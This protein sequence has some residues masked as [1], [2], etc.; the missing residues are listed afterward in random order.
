MPSENNHIDNF[1][2]NKASEA[3]VDASRMDADWQQMKEMLVK[4]SSLPSSRTLRFRRYLPYA[5]GVIMVVTTVT[6]MLSPGKKTK[7]EQLAVAT[8]KTVAPGVDRT[9]K[10]RTTVPFKNTTASSTTSSNIAP[11]RKQAVKHEAKTIKKPTFATVK[12]SA[13]VVTKD[14]LTETIAATTP[15]PK[16][17]FNN[18]YNDLKKPAQEFNVNT[19]G[20]TTILCAEGSSLFVPAGAFQ[21]VAGLAITGTVRISIQE[22][23]SFAD[24][25]SNKLSTTSNSIPLETGGMLSINASS[26]GE[27]VVIK[28]GTSLDLKMP[29]HSFNPQMQLFTGQHRLT[30]MDTVKA[31]LPGA[32]NTEILGET[33][34]VHFDTTAKSARAN[35][36]SLA[37]LAGSID[38][39]PVGQQQYF[40]AENRKVIT[41]FNATDNPYHIGSDWT[42]K[43]IAKFAIPYSASIS[44]TEMKDILETKYGR[45][46]DKIKVKRAWRS[47]V[48]KNRTYKHT[49]T[50][51][52]ER[53]RVI[54]DWY[55]TTFV[56]DSIRI[57][58]QLACRLKM[59]SPEDSL[60]WE[61]KFKQQLETAMKQKWAYQEMLQKRNEYSFKITNLGWINCDRFLEYPS[62]RLTA[63][64]FKA[65]AGFDHKNFQAILVFDKEKSVMQG[66]LQNDEVRFGNIPVGHTVHLICTG[67]RNG[68]MQVSMQTFV[69]EKFQKP[70]LLFEET[71]KDQFRQKLAQL[72]NVK[73]I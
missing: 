64:A 45:Y 4:P 68:K 22:F 66:Y 34:R 55:K 14:S 2:R 53:D 42:G 18:F 13:G 23:Y 41:L 12:Q 39:S 10:P 17:I 67:V 57:P 8:K 43:S 56:G 46:Y 44:T 26:G 19:K 1:L 29:T 61:E 24:I 62:S 30:L 65:G 35:D 36:F 28:P 11:Q 59:I 33:A 16:T 48:D 7:S 3:A 40:I 50:T 70:R 73:T 5:A 37:S 38:W 20:D 72:G 71:D 47:W 31:V 63:Y 9:V 69:I 25:I 52:K 6:I 21:T 32:F 58:L 27:P 49:G 15:D 51:K 60:A 54:G